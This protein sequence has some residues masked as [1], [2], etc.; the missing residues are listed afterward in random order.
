MISRVLAE[1]LGVADDVIRVIDYLR[2][3]DD[4]VGVADSV[5]R[6]IVALRT[7]DDGV[8]LSDE[9][10]EGATVLWRIA[11]AYMVMRQ[12]HN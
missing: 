8:G 10:S 2:V 4:G 6:V 9:M 11:W 12:T 5:A 1:S 3:Q 7:I